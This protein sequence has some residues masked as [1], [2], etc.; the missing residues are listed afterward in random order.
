M[1]RLFSLCLATMLAGNLVLHAQN[2]E[3]EL[4]VQT[5]KSKVE[6]QPTM[7]G[8]FF[9]DINFGADGGLYAELVKNRSFEFPQTLMGWN[10]F[11]EVEV[12]TDEAPFPRNPHYVRLSR[13][14]HPH[15]QTGLENEGFRGIGIEHGK[16][17]RFS[18]WARSPKGGEQ[19]IRVELVGKDNN[20]IGQKEMF[21]A[22][23]DWKQYE[24]MIGTFK[25]DQHARLRIFFIGDATLDLDHISLFPKDTWKGRSNGLRKDLAQA[26][27]DLNP[28]VFRFPGGC[29]VEGTT[30]DTRYNWKETLGPVEN[31]P[32]NENR[33]NF[34]FPYR[35]FP[36]YFQSR[37]MGFYELFLLSEDIGA[38]P[39]PIINCGLSCQF[40][41]ET[42]DAH[43][44]MEHL[45]C[46]IQDALDLIE[47]ANGAPT[48]KWGK[49]RADMGHPEPFH[50]KFI[51]VG[52]EQWGTEYVERLEAFMKVLK[53]EHPEVA[54]IGSAGP[55]GFQDRFD[56]LWKEMRRLKVEL[57]DEHDYRSPE[58]FLA[59]GPKYDNYDRKGP[60]VFAGE[61]ACHDS[62][63][64]A[65]GS[66]TNSFLSAMCEAAYMTGLE[67]NAD[68]VWMATYAPLFAHV[69]GWQW[70][71]DMIWFDNTRMVK[72]PNYHVQQMF[73]NNTG[74]RVVPVTLDKQPLSGQEGLF[75]SASVD[76][77]QGKYYIKIVNTT[78]KAMP[79]K[80]SFKGLKKQDQLVNGELITL[81]AS[82]LKMENTLD[83][84]DKV[85]PKTTTV[86]LSGNSL[87]TT[88]D[89]QTVAIYTFVRK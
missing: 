55:A 73:G 61:Y 46:Y 67:R 62:G 16:E 43:Q 84:P 64:V 11:G 12:R 19:K 40:Q 85:T 80:L 13:P 35:M 22:S 86:A 78:E 57:V 83:E 76:N 50:L 63:G 33:W 45:D 31:R 34:C 6:I 41:N 2:T 9:E 8:I 75:A 20:T 36:D 47:F 21:I 1:K 72:T 3:R 79:L 44:P 4:V 38:E 69:D 87:S 32:L 66:N 49:I 52:N 29:V 14:S 48:T 81:Q 28:G 88:I 25:S 26:L 24:T 58:W 82:E 37:G 27:S 68:V 74:D 7:Y 56:Y 65:G 17:Y 60:K 71:P 42:M 10:T 23:T 54:I 59:S 51:G 15:R 70:K 89:P 77:K 39:L 5:D 53:K 30:L 18:V